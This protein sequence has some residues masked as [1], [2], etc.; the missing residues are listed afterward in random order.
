M[1]QVFPISPGIKMTQTSIKLFFER[2]LKEANDADVV[3]PIDSRSA[4]AKKDA[5]TSKRDT[6][7]KENK[8][9][10]VIVIEDCEINRGKKPS[11]GRRSAPS[12]VLRDIVGKKRKSEV[13]E[14][15]THCHNYKTIHIPVRP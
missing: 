1:T 5:A 9:D 12:N 6:A 7:D 14:K 4:A 11:G 13:M 8:D 15:V 3:I 2:K 10:D